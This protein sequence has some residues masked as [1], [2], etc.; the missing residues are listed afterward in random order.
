[1]NEATLIVLVA[2]FY[3]VVFSWAIV[4]ATAPEAREHY[5]AFSDWCADQGGHLTKENSLIHGGLHCVYPNGT[6]VRI[7]EVNTTRMLENQQTAS[8]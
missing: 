8:K 5:Q 4:D 3:L 1:M 2:L 7:A 6:S